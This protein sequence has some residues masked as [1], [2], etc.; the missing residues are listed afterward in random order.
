MAGWA[1][2]DEDGADGPVG[3][4]GDAVFW[5]EVMGPLGLGIFC[6]VGFAEGVQKLYLHW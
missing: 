4:G 1:S 5:T 6:G 2:P 3:D